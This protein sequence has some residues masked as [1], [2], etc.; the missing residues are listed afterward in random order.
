MNKKGKIKTI[1]G[2]HC[3]EPLELY[4]QDLHCVDKIVGY[5]MY[6]ICY[7]CNKVVLCNI[8]TSK[9]KPKENVDYIIH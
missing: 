5:A 2:K 7:K 9:E 3:G 4:L 6:G 1:N 8:F